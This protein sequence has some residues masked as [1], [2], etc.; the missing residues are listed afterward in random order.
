MTTFKEDGVYVGDRW[1][2]ARTYATTWF[3]MDL[4]AS[5]PIGWFTDNLGGGGSASKC[6]NELCGR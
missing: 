4:L 2:V 6:P 3:P 5:F 1:L